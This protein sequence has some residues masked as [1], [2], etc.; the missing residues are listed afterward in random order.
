MKKALIGMMLFV[1]FALCASAQTTPTPEPKPPSPASPNEPPVSPCPK[2]EIN[3]PQRPI[4]D[5]EQVGFT[6]QLSG[7]DPKVVP[8]YNWSLSAGTLLGGQ[9]TRSIGVDSTGAAADKAITATVQLGGF[10]PECT[11][12]AA[13]TLYIAGPAKKLD[14][15][16]A[17][18][19]D[20]EKERLDAFMSNVTEKEHAY[21]FV[22]AGR[23]SPRGQASSGIKRI[24][25]YLLKAGTPSDRLVTIDGGYREEISHELWLV[26]IGAES[27]RSSPTVSSKDIVFP[28]TTPPVKKP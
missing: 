23:T 7:G 15:F 25:A 4:R 10:A 13:V 14:E 27:P 6:A 21:I 9:G 11:A 8:M 17:L 18:A 20:K 1:A 16:G 24:R 19:E 3:K 5:G 28:K 22:Y 26:P 12:D 2:L